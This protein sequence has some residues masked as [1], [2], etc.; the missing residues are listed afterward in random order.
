MDYVVL[1]T[2]V[3]SQSIKDRLPG[4]LVVKLAGPAWCIAFVT[5]GELWQW[6]EI[7]HW[8]SRNRD[9]LERWLHRVV[10]LDSDETVSRTWGPV[11]ADARRRGRPPPT[12]DSWI[13]ACC[14]AYAL[15]LATRNTKDFANFA[16]HDGLRLMAS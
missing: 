5:L 16:E 15:P 8:G 2:D 12:N 3:A 4:P 13:A 14:L 7:R 6:A 11:C 10:I 1:D 9:R